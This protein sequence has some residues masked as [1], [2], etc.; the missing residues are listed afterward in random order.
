MRF[1]LSFTIFL[2]I[3]FSGIA[4]DKR[5]ANSPDRHSQIEAIHVAF[6]TDRLSLTPEEAQK[7]WPVYNNYQNELDGIFDQKRKNRNINKDNPEETLRA[8]LALDRRVLETKMKYQKSFT[9]VISAQKVLALYR[10]ETDFREYLMKQLH[11][12]DGNDKK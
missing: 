7:F 9:V 2:L 3:T 5:P 1:I 4:Q 8:D 10:A 6:L 12:R 11:S